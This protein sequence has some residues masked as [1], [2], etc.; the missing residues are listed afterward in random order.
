MLDSSVWLVVTLLAGIAMGHFH[1]D[2]REYYLEKQ[3]A[4][5][6]QKRK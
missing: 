5:E 3:I 6:I 2:R 4:A 1:H